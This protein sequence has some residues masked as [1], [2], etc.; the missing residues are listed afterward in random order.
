MSVNNI[1][2][3]YGRKAFDPVLDLTFDMRQKM[4][5]VKYDTIVGT[6][7]SGTVFASRVAAS[8]RKKLVIVRKPD[9]KTHDGHTVI[10]DVGKRWLFVDDFISRG[11]TIRRVQDSMDE[12]YDIY[13]WKFENDKGVS[14]R[15]EFVGVYEYDYARFTPF[16]LFRDSDVNERV[17][18]DR[19][20]ARRASSVVAP[21]KIDFTPVTFADILKDMKTVKR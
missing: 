6:G 14:V 1:D 17:L 5:G 3:Y 9:E 7:V 15:P 4:R 19:K 2:D 12:F 8:M 16:N 13:R 20:Y 18:I 11:T 10:G 21:K